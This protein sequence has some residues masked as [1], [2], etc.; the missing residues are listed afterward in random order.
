LLGLLFCFAALGAR[1]LF[2]ALFDPPDDPVS[3]LAVLQ[4]AFALFWEVLFLIA[5]LWI[6]LAAWARRWHDLGLFGGLSL[7]LFIP[8]VDVA[9]FIILLLAPGTAGPNRYGLP[10]I[11]VQR[12]TE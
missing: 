2:S 8:I 11:P 9:V 5:W 6:S 12:L 4:I 7:V 10:V 3:T 1:S